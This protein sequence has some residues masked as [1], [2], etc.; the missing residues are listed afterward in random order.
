MDEAMISPRDSAKGAK[1]AFAA[2]AEL[3]DPFVVRTPPVDVTGARLQER[4]AVQ[5]FSLCARF[6]WSRQDRLA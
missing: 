4:L 6:C 2:I 3:F 5:P 1:G